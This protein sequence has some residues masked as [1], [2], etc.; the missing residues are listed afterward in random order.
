LTDDRP[1]VVVAE[2]DEDILM[3]VRATLT[4]RGYAVE[5]ARDG[6]AALALVRERAPAA[7]VLDIAMPE[8]SGLD[9]LSQVRSDPAIAD[10]PIILLSARAQENDV[11][12]GYELGASKYIRKPFSPRE[13]VTAIDELEGR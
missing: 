7:A 13:L 5:V 10:L 11:A 1:G 6:R 3:L 8:L 9:V 2:D 12:R 4:G